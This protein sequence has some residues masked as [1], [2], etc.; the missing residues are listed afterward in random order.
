[1][2][3]PSKEIWLSDDLKLKYGFFPTDKNSILMA[4]CLRARRFLEKLI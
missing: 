1:M 3:Y 2:E 4:L